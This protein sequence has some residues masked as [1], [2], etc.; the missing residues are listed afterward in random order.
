MV[1]LL[2]DGVKQKFSHAKQLRPK[3]SG[4]H[5]A[6]RVFLMAIDQKIKVSVRSQCHNNVAKN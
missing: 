4:V 5:K 6:F 3:L 2:F 1:S